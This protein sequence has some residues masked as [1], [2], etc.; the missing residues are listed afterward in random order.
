MP[1]LAFIAGIALPDF[2]DAHR[3]DLRSFAQVVFVHDL[4]GDK[5]LVAEG[6]IFAVDIVFFAFSVL[7]YRYAYHLA[8]FKDDLVSGKAGE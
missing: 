7:G 6:R 1:D 2:F 8:V 4:A 3:P 5:A